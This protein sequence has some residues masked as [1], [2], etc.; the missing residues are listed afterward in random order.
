MGLYE[1]HCHTKE[2]SACSGVD[3]ERVVNIHK[4]AGF[5][6]ICIT[7]HYHEHYFK[8]HNG[9]LEKDIVDSYLSGYR[10]ARLVGEK[11]GL[12]VLLG[13]EIKF[14]EGPNDYL[15]Y[16]ISEN[17]IYD[18]PYMFKMGLEKFSAFSKQ[19]GLLLLQAHP[20]RDNMERVNHTYLDGVETIN[21]NLRHYARN[22]LSKKYAEEN[23]LLEMGGSD[24]HRECDIYLAAMDFN[25]EINDNSDLI[26]AIRN[27][28]FDIIHN[29]KQ[30]IRL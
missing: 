16:G 14:H 5:E 27:R 3:A 15:V 18:N 23:D 7:D 30:G 26:Q 22:H 10:R 24:F 8:S 20:F 19:E 1:I 12:N 28:N 25:V 17:L 6:G 13:M 4:E 9:L 11:V 29:T 21:A 2:V